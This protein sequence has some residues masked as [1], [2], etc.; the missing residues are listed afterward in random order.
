MLFT[1]RLLFAARSLRAHKH[2]KCCI[3]RVEHLA[4]SCAEAQMLSMIVDHAGDFKM[5]VKHIICCFFCFEYRMHIRLIALAREVL[6]NLYS[7][8]TCYD[9]LLSKFIQHTNMLR[10]FVVAYEMLLKIVQR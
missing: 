4:P 10:L 1:A 9:C 2:P 5:L 6:S 7:I 3:H 8:Q